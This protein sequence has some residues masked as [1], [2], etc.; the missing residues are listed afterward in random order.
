MAYGVGVGVKMS[1]L[2]AAPPIIII[3]FQANGFYE[4]AY[5]LSWIG[6]AQVIRLPFS[7]YGK[8]LS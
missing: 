4:G 1:L 2:L 7:R 6:Q 5:R 3:V 8:N